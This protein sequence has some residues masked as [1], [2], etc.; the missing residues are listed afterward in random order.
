MDY[1]EM[2]EEAVKS[3]ALIDYALG[4][5]DDGCNDLEGTLFRIAELKGE[6]E[7][8]EVKARR[9]ESLAMAV[10]ADQT[11]HDVAL[12]I[13]TEEHDCC[14]EDLITLRTAAN[15]LLHQIDIGDFTDSNGHS[16]KMLKATH[17]LMRVLGA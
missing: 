14:A 3:L 4:I 12:R 17:D 9:G 2:F 1:K 8:L 5:G 13:K 11:S 7:E 15:A 16:A 10:M 6:Q